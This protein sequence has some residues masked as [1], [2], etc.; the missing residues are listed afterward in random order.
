MMLYVPVKFVSVML[1]HFHLNFLGKT[2]SP[3]L[4]P[5]PLIHSVIACGTDL[6]SIMKP[7]ESLKGVHIQNIIFL[8]LNQNICCG[9]SK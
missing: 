4:P 1:G 2:R 7:Q 3:R 8:F 6:Y 9:Y 5:P